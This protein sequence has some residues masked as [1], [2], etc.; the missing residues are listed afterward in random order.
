MALISQY[1]LTTKNVEAFF[2]SLTTA[3]APE[4]FTQQFLYGLEFKSTNDRL[5][6][7]LLKGLGFLDEASIPTQRYYEFL[8]QSKSKDVLAEAIR[9]AYSDLFS[10]NIKA[11]EMSASEVKNKLKT[12]TQGK[13]SDKVLGLM[14]NTFIALAG[15]AVWKKP[16]QKK[17]TKATKAKTTPEPVVVV[18]EDNDT[19]VKKGNSQDRSKSKELKFHYNIQ[20]HLPASR[21][22]ATYDAIFKA[23]K[24]HLF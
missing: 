17:A 9:E 15:Y 13:Y 10:L 11:H 6:I 12:L 24:A 22:Q 4:S 3:Q 8:D 21:D 14:A 2:N 1:L 5:F 19:F 18:D 23:L 20:I 7:G 16:E